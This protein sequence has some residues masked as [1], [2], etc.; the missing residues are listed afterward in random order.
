M[1]PAL[2]ADFSHQVRARA[3]KERQRLVLALHLQ[4]LTN[5]QIAE[6]LSVSVRTVYR[7]LTEIEDERIRIQQILSDVGANT[8]DLHMSLTREMDADIKDLFDDE[9]NLRKVSEWPRVW[10]QGL[11]TGVDVERE[12]V[13]S[14]AGVTVRTQVKKLRIESRTKVKELL[15]KLRPVD[16]LVTAQP[17]PP[18]DRPPLQ[19]QINVIGVSK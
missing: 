15:A 14:E 7:D 4:D 2:A 9:G 16:A 1:L 13:E 18:D 8:N 5:D 3:A 12:S 17:A 10:R 19:V 6:Q 11:I